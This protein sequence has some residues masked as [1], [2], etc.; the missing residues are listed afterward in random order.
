MAF[1]RVSLA[2][3]RSSIERRLVGSFLGMLVVVA[4][5][6]AG[7][8]LY[9]S[10]RS[11]GPCL[12]HLLRV[13]LAVAFVEVAFLLGKSWRQMSMNIVSSGQSLPMGNSFCMFTILAGALNSFASST[14]SMGT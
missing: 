9:V 5:G 11:P 8:P 10:N 7:D 1:E 14:T 6:G 2:A 12:V 3:D 13:I 4:A